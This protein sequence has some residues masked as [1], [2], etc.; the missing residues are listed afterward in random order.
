MVV[1]VYCMQLLAVVVVK[2]HEWDVPFEVPTSICPIH[3]VPSFHLYGPWSLWSTMFLR[4]FSIRC[5]K[6]NSEKFNISGE[7]LVHPYS[8]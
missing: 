3:H 4:N 7:T 6:I 5:H 1:T 8:D 2:I